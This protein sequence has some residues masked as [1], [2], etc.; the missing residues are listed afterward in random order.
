M[1]ITKNSIVSLIV[2]LSLLVM[3]G[4]ESNSNSPTKPITQIT[5]GTVEGTV[6]YAGTISTVLGVL[7]TC[8]D[9]SAT[10][11]NDGKFILKN[12]PSGFQT[13]KAT[14]NDFSPYARNIDVVENST[15]RYD[16]DMTSSSIKSLRGTVYQKDNLATLANVRVIL[17]NDTTFTDAFGKYQ[18]PILYQGLKTIRAEKTG[19]ISSVNDIFLSNSDTQYDITIEK[20]P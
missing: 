8:G 1:S 2:L 17:V 5:Y 13:L 6:Y 20:I 7:V 19:Y 16:I 4:C 3:L 14:K 18:L 9:I 11:S 10:T 15:S 12:V